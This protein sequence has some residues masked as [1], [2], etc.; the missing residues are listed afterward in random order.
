METIC[1]AAD[2]ECGV[3]VEAEETR[4]FGGR[5]CGSEEKVLY[6]EFQTPELSE[7]ES[8]V[9]VSHDGLAFV[10]NDSG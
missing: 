7:L 10:R 9:R 8:V 5:H 2:Q 6:P 4:V 3:I 1:R